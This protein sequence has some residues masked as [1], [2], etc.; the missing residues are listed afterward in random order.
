MIKFKLTDN[1]NNGITL[2]ALVITIIVLL[3]LAGVTIASLTGDNGILT[4]AQQAKTKTE[5]AEKEE[6]EKLNQL[7]N[8]MGDVYTATSTINGKS[9]GNSYN[10]TIPAGF[11]P[12]DTEGASW[13]D[14]SNPPSEEAVNA[15]L[16]I[17]DENGN[18]FVW[19][20]CTITG[21]EGLISYA[22]DKQYN[23]GTTASKQWYYNEYTDWTDATGE[24]NKTSVEKYGG[25]Y[26]ARYEAGVPSDAPFY[27][28]EEGT[29]YYTSGT[30]PSKNVDTYKPVS[31]ANNQ[32]WNYISQQNAVTVSQKMYEGN[33][34]VKSQLIDSYAWDTIMNWM[35]SEKSGIAIDSSNYGNYYNNTSIEANTLYALHRYGAVT[36]TGK[37]NGKGDYWTVATKYKKGNIQSGAISLTESNRDQYEFTDYD[38]ENY[39]YTVRKEMATG[40]SDVTKVKNIY[41][42]AGNIW[43]WTTETGYHNTGS[44]TQYAVVRGGIFHNYGGNYPVSHRNGGNSVADSSFSF[45]FRVVLYL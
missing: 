35:E 9:E 40:A 22:Q 27:A 21:E 26:V 34:S 23:D 18:Q 12:I 19:V 2:I 38:D 8:M 24:A 5:E 39:T 42:I 43:E 20:P 31:K 36:T 14:G 15:G 29:I 17:E 6:N 41:D 37:E 13:G 7:A 44:G 11:K 25:F 1:T 10:P 4:K 32:S 3:I 45:G 28:N 33:S 30:N 16:V